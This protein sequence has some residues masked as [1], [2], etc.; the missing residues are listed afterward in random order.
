MVGAYKFEEYTFDCMAGF[1]SQDRRSLELFINSDF[2]LGGI[3][4]LVVMS[5]QGPIEIQGSITAKLGPEAGFYGI[6]EQYLNHDHITKIIWPVDSLKY[7]YPGGGD[8]KYL[9]SIKLLDKL[10]VERNLTT[11]EIK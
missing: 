10:P 4:D 1:I 3:V 8:F 7:F 9:I 6:L 5:Q 2:P 11:Q